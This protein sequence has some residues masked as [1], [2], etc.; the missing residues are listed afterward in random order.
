MRHVGEAFMVD[1]ELLSSSD[2]FTVPFSALS[3]HSCH[4]KGI[5]S[6]F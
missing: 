6:H 2:Q 1:N 5:S 3:A 4:R